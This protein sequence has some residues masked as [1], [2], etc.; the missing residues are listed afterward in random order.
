M[1]T[2]LFTVFQLAEQKNGQLQEI[3]LV[4]TLINYINKKLIET[5]SRLE[6]SLLFLFVEEHI[7][8]L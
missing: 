5:K 8:V 3:V 2:Q 1:V 4:L 7:S 6:S